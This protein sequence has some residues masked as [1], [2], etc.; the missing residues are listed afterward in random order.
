M[1]LLSL[2]NFLFSNTTHSV[3]E[4]V[5]KKINSSEVWCIFLKTKLYDKSVI[6]KF[7]D[8]IQAPLTPL[9]FERSILEKNSRK[10]T[11][12][13]SILEGVCFLH[14]FPKIPLKASKWQFLKK[15]KL[16][17][18][19]GD[20][21]VKLQ[22]LAVLRHLEGSLEKKWRKY[23]SFKRYRCQ[24]GLD[25]MQKFSKNTFWNCHIT[26]YSKICITPLSYLLF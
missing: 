12:Y 13:F 18:L 21:E 16:S 11:H 24:G 23:A 20:L 19:F 4:Q 7:F 9:S 26:W 2:F 15:Y 17:A 3:P 10:Y 6:W 5:Y 8:Y 1:K 25:V 14:F 22:F